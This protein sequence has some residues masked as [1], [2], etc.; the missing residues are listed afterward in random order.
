M[1]YLN[2]RRTNWEHFRNIINE[3][4]NCKIFLKSEIELEAAIENFTK[5]MQK[6]TRESTPVMKP[7]NNMQ[8]CSINVKIEE[9]RRI[10]KQWQL[11]RSAKDK[12]KFN[13]TTKELKI[14][15]HNE[16]NLAI[17]KCLENL[18]ATVATDYSLWKATRIIKQPQQ[19]IPP[20]RL[21]NGNWARS[22]DDKAEAFASGRSL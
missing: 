9:K 19:S 10:R 20:I 5:V 11:T 6:A 1:P 17:Q 21:S 8:Y 16:K 22:D 4:L 7:Q 18:T 14:L 15:L 12:T 13:K 2:N 3:E